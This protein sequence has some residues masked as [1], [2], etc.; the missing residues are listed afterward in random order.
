MQYLLFT[1]SVHLLVVKPCKIAYIWIAILLEVPNHLQT[2]TVA[3]VGLDIHP[4]IIK[5]QVQVTNMLE[6]DVGMLYC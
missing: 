2:R 5:F 6:N 1:L 3:T 4:Y